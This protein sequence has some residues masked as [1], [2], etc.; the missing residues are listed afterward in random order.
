MGPPP[1]TTM[2]IE[3]DRETHR[4]R[5]FCAEFEFKLIFAGS[6]CELAQ[7]KHMAAAGRRT[8]VGRRID[9]NG[10]LL[11]YN[12]LIPNGL[13]GPFWGRLTCGFGRSIQAAGDEIESLSI[14]PVWLSNPK[15]SLVRLPRP[16]PKLLIRLRRCCDVELGWKD[17]VGDVF[18]ERACRDH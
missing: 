3:F 13:D 15:L 9:Q 6:K 11:N 18:R 7:G 14:Q 5:D 10:F 12:T 1:R 8:F 2:D 16:D 17:W 4:F